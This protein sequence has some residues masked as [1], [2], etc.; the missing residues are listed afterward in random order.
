MGVF[1][2]FPTFRADEP[3]HLRDIHTTVLHQLGLEQNALSYL[4]QGRRERL[5]E[6]HG[7]VIRSIV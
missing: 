3:H 6:V 7:E 2:G 1:Y 5:T 4:H